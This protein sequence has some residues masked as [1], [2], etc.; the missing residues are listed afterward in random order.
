[1]EPET[2][3]QRSD[4]GL[5]Q[6]VLEAITVVLPRVLDRDALVIA[7]EMKLMS[8][9]GMRSA[10]MLELLRELEDNPDIQ[11][12]VE[13]ITEAAM[14]SVGDLADFVASHASTNL[15]CPVHSLSHRTRPRGYGGSSPREVT[16]LCTAPCRRRWARALARF[17]YPAPP[18]ECSTSMTTPRAIRRTRPT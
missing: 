15:A 13:D 5:R 14:V 7:P 6:R 4:A 1:M 2:L 3:P 10:S 16:D 17:G 11:I 9:L 8:D 18:G 12:D